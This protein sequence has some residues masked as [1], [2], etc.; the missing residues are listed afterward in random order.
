MFLEL[1]RR[2]G[3]YAIVGLAA[4]T[5]LSGRRLVFSGFSNKPVL[6]K[7]SSLEEVKAELPTPAAD[8]YNSPSTKLHLAKVLLER[9]WNRLDHHRDGE[10]HAA[11]PQRCRAPASGRF[12]AGRARAHRLAYRPSTASAARARCGVNGD[13]VRG[14]LMLAVQADAAAWTRS[15]DCRTP[16]SSRSCRRRSTRKTRCSAAS[17]LREC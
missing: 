3:D 9:A 11:Y 4:V 15:K 14:C 7:P 6:V 10:R 12:P 16:R 8:L 5:K 1:A 2:H 13:I 17:A